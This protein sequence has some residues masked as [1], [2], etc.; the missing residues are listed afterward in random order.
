[1]TCATG[2]MGKGAV[3]ELLLKFTS[4]C[5][6]GVASLSNTD[7]YFLIV[8]KEIHPSLCKPNEPLPIGYIYYPPGDFHPYH[9][10]IASACS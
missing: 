8:E 1:M 10:V 9:L 6:P 4:V 3:V 2:Y 7:V 5:A